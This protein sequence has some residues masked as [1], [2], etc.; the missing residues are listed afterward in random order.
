MNVTSELRVRSRVSPAFLE[1]VKGKILTP[2]EVDVMPTGP[3]RLMRFIS[4]LPQSLASGSPSQLG[5]RA[6]TSL[7]STEPSPN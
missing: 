4:S 3:T 6:G 5:N 1:Q 2:N 7:A